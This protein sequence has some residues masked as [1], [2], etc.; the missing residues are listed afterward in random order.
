M[1]LRLPPNVSTLQLEVFKDLT[2]AGFSNPLAAAAVIEVE[3]MAAGLSSQLLKAGLLGK[4]RFGGRLQSFRRQ[5]SRDRWSFQ[6]V[7]KG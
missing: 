3:A 6:I 4:S 2:A 1:S 7:R 5:W